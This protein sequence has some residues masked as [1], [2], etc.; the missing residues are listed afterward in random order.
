[1]Y[2]GNCGAELQTGSSFCSKCGQ[3]VAKPPTTGQKSTRSPKRGKGCGLLLL[4]AAIIMII[5]Y[6]LFSQGSR[7]PSVA[8]PT[9]AKANATER[10][11]PEVE[12]DVTGVME[13]VTYSVRNGDAAGTPTSKPS[14]TPTATPV[15]AVVQAASANLREGPGT[16]Y[17]VIGS[18]RNGDTV[19]VVG[20]VEDSSWYKIQLAKG[21]EGWVSSTL[22]KLPVAPDQIAL[23]PTPTASPAADQRAVQTVTARAKITTTQASS[24]KDSLE[25]KLACINKGYEVDEGDVTIARFRY[26]LDSIDSKTPESRQEVADMLVMGQQILRDKYGK[27]V[28]LL[29]LTEGANKAIPF[30]SEVSFAEIMAAL[31]S[32]IK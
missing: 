25:Y 28:N 20:R 13:V 26:L 3:Q 22:L 8:T 5:S 2:C 19:A 14:A 16:S 1:M 12:S 10:A 32:M 29:E 30:S 4:V 9:S 31:I 27:E 24:A 15:V 18:F 23:A 6:S 7:T 17:G 11:T 21:V